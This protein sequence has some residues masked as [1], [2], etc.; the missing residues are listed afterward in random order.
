M[1]DQWQDRAECKSTN[2]LFFYSETGDSKLNRKNEAMAKMFCSKCQ[3][4]AEC[5]H[6]AIENDEAF[7]I[8]GSFSTKERYALTNLYPVEEFS[9]DLCKMLVNKE[10]KSIK[11]QILI[12]NHGG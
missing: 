9:I 1:T 8:W 11:A 12:K 5:L 4:A 3:V 7:G 10:I 2:I 6:Y